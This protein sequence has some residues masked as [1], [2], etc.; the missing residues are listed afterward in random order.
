MKMKLK[1][2]HDIIGQF[3]VGFY[4]A[5]MVADVVT[6]ISKSLESDECL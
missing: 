5:F 6:V 2:G 1:D 3:G 4:A